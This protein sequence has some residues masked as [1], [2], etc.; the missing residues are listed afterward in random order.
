[1]K[2]RHLAI[3][4][5]LTAVIA[6]LLFAAVGRR[7]PAGQAPLMRLDEQSLNVLRNEFNDGADQTR[8]ILLLSPT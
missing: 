3:I 8:I 7:V 5:V 4:G 6:V 2:P 1:M